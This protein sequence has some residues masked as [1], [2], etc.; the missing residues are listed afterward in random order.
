[1]LGKYRDITKRTTHHIH[2]LTIYRATQSY[3][4]TEEGKQMLSEE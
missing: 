4:D 2:K 3:N 1:M